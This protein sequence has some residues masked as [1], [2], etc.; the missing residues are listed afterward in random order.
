MPDLLLIQYVIF[1]LYLLWIGC[2]EMNPGPPKQTVLLSVFDFRRKETE[3]CIFQD[4]F[5][6]PRRHNM[7]EV[8]RNALQCYITNHMFGHVDNVNLN[9]ELYL[10]DDT[11]FWDCKIRLDTSEKCKHRDSNEQRH[12]RDLKSLRGVRKMKNARFV[13]ALGRKRS[14]FTQVFFIYP[15]SD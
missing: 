10:S 9:M 2:V 14:D 4:R 11:R 8:S 7:N 15:F 13:A 1:L 6:L 12:N 5:K 3:H